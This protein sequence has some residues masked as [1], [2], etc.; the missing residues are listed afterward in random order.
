M[1]ERLKTTIRLK[2]QESVE[3]S[4]LAFELTKENIMNGK[5]KLY[6]ESD[7]V[8]FAIEKIAGKIALDANGDLIY[9]EEKK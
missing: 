6:S 3:L 4:K 5:Q 2:K 9:T 7:L 1:T 8:H